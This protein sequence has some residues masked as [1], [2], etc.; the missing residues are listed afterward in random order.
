MAAIPEGFAVHLATDGSTGYVF[1][2]KD[3]LDPCRFALFSDQAGLI[4]TGEPLQ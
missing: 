4:Y 2:V 3:T 1:S